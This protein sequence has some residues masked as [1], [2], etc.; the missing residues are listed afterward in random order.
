MNVQAPL[1][2]LEPWGG[3]VVRLERLVPSWSV[4]SSCTGSRCV[5]C[6]FSSGYASRVCPDHE[7]SGTAARAAHAARGGQ[8][9][10][11]VWL[12]TR[13][14]RSIPVCGQVSLEHRRDI[15]GARHGAQSLP[16]SL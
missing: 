9:C 6:H 13:A 4:L 8:Q 1:A 2:S 10:M 3:T 16:S 14:S 7:G 12:S 15:L 11:V 5:R